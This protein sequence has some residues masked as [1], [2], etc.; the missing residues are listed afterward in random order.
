MAHTMVS[1]GTRVP[2]DITSP[3]ASSRS[4]VPE[5]SPIRPSTTIGEAPT[6]M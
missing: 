4:I 6:S 1:A 2:S 5:T 3:S